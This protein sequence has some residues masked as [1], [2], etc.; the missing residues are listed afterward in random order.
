MIEHLRLEIETLKREEEDINRV[1][2]MSDPVLSEVEA[3]KK[4]LASLKQEIAQLQEA[5]LKE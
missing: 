2:K 3:D 5:R 4:I 1:L